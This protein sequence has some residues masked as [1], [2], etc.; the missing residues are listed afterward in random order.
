MRDN[1]RNPTIMSQPQHPAFN[2]DRE[3]MR[4]RASLRPISDKEEGWN[5]RRLPEGIYGFT[6][7]PASEEL[8]LFVA[9]IYQCFEVQKLIGGE[10]CHVGYVTEAE[11]Q[12][13]QQ[14]LGSMV[15]DLYP[16]P[17]GAST[18]L[19][20]VPRS[21]TDRTRSP[22]RDRGNAMKMDIAPRAE[23]LGAA[24]SGG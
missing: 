11:F 3:E 2:P 24:G 22:T 19:I 20:S 5:I 13:Y 14:G 16:E 8:P 21:R 7:A 18:K 15:M 10:I 4:R 9:P 6:G 17:Y 23:L 1:V 12:Q